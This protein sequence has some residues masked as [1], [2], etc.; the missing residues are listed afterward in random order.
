MLHAC[1]L[2][3]KIRGR[4]RQ[5]EGTAGS[6]GLGAGVAKAEWGRGR[7]GGRVLDH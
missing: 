6:Q 5:A 4:A 1:L 3:R 2:N 7:E